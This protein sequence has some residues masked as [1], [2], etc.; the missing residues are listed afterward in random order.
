MLRTVNFH[1]SLVEL[2]GVKSAEFD[3]DSPLAL[4]NALRS[5]VKK[6][7][8]WCSDH[9]LAVV[10]LDGSDKAVS[11]QSHELE[12]QFGN[13]TQIHL[14]PEAEGSGF[15]AAAILAAFQ[16]GAYATALYYIAVNIAISFVVGLVLQALSPQPKATKDAARPE[17]NPSFVFNGALNVQEQGYAV[18]LVYGIHMTGSVV[19]S[20]GIS[21]EDIAYVPPASPGNEIFRRV[22]AAVGW[23]WG[24]N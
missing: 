21:V 7:R 15:E 17:E 16:A 18:P 4:F 10:L 13:A 22:V 9:N 8:Q 1:G 19:V 24:A 3:V 14:V 12:M 2:A 11:L 5:Q 23:Q 20:A 6:F